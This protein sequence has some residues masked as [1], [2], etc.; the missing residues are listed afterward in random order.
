MLRFRNF[1]APFLVVALV[2][3]L[4]A[5]DL[6]VGG[7]APDIAA[8]DI[9]GNSVNLQK[10]L[11]ESPDLVVLFF[12]SVKTGEE[13]ALKLQVLNRLYGK[14]DLKIIALGLEDEKKALIDFSE[15]LGIKYFIIPKE[16]TRSSTWRDDIESLPI[17]LFLVTHD[18]TIE[19]IIRGGKGTQA[20]VLVY[21][22]ENFF[23]QRKTAAAQAIADAAIE[24][25]EDETSARELKGFVLVAEGKLDAAEAEFGKIDSNTGLAKV[26][27]EKGELDKA[28]TLADQAGADGY[29]QTVKGQA[30]MRAGKMDEGAATLK[31]ADQSNASGWQQSENLNAQGRAQHEKGDADAAIGQYRQALALDPYNVIALSNE[32]AAHRQKGDLKAAN[33]ALEQASGIRD[34]EMVTIMM[35]QVQREMKESNDIK[36]AEL[37]RSQIADLKTRF[38]E[39][40]ASGEAGKVDDWSTRP[41]IL[42]FLPSRAGAPVFFE[43]A[44]TDVV[45][46]REIEVRLMNDKRVSIVERAMLDQ[47]LQELNLGSSD[48]ASKDTQRRLGK[49]LSAGALGFIDFAQL[50]ADNEMYLRLVDTET[51]E[52]T[53]QTSHKVD[54]NRPGVVVDAMVTDLLKAV[55]NG[56]ELKGLIADA[57]E[58]EAIII[59]LGEKHGVKMGQ[60]F[61]VIQDGDPIEVGGRVIAYR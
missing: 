34:D 16:E 54:E 44:G 35:Q 13:I 48:L 50:G 36:R 23:Q 12:F 42:A 4:A 40:K 49:V 58:E 60:V 39:M 56:S 15:D 26:A 18:R 32:G 61:N 55:A 46:Q 37:I 47:L 17:T 45:L 27:L 6:K 22:A 5:A 20:K 31:A 25:G 57:A 38:D 43:R 19:R 1:V 33:A 11:D 14:E 21:A 9:H 29:A 51:T 2:A 59:N 24:A 3:S 52:I 41:I 10:V 53:F 30:Q 8:V 28:V 7:P